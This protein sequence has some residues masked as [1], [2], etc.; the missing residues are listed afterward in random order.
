MILIKMP[1][2]KVAN[3]FNNSRLERLKTLKLNS[4]KNSHSSF[5]SKTNGNDSVTVI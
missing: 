4:L 5:D 3:K 2:N 1:F